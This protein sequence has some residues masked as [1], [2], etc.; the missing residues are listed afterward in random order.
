[1]REVST[2]FPFSILNEIPLRKRIAVTATP[3]KVA[4]IVS[5]TLPYDYRNSVVSA[6]E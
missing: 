2:T 5:G 3:I 4:E 1:M 6:K